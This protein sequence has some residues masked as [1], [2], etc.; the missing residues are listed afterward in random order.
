MDVT[1]ATFEAE[2]LAA[3]DRT[4]VVVDLWATWCQPCRTLGPI[5]ERVVAET[6]GAV[7]LAKV[8]IDAN[9]RVAQMFRVQSI[10]AVFALRNRQVVDQFLG[11]Q[12]EAAVREFVQRLLPADVEDEIT[13]LIAVGDEPSLRRALELKPGHEAASLALASLLVAAGRNDEALALLEGLPESLESRHIAAL[14][15]SDEGMPADVDQ[16]LESLLGQVRDDP[17][18]RQRFLDL[19][20]LL[21]PGDPRTAQFR[22]RLASALF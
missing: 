18:A 12:P 11:A 5:L 19:L 17:D 7:V 9:P 1:D 21:G 22:R 10:P 6:N 8:D 4:A 15:R 13:A 2:V 20:E 16:Q 14:A 3:S